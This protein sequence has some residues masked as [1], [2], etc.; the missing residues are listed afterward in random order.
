MAPYHEYREESNGDFQ[1]M[2]A[3]VDELDP[4]SVHFMGV[5]A[6]GKIVLLLMWLPRLLLLPQKLASVQ[7]Q[8]QHI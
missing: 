8:C 7:N 1:R 4:I 5:I 3:L 2:V 6:G